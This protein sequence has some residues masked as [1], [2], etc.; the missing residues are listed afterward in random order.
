MATV[1]DPPA[2]RPEGF[3]WRVWADA[4]C[5]GL[6][7]LVPVPVLDLVL[8]RYFRRRM[9]RAIAQARGRSLDERAARRLGRGDALLSASGC[10]AVPMIAVWYVLKRLWRKLIYVLAV[11]DASRALSEYWHRAGLI[12]HMVRSGHLEPGAPLEWPLAA[13]EHVLRTADTDSLRAVARQV[14]EGS[15]HVARTLWRARRRGTTDL[16]ERQRSFLAAHWAGVE[17]SVAEVVARYD[18]LL[19]TWAKDAAATA[20]GGDSG[21]KPLSAG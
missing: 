14:A 11:A 3:A 10:L 7:P 2:R 13:A 1:T 20:S 15:R 4:T 5:A 21:G 9:P 6:T 18:A 19:R 8:E 12:D 17:R 16:T